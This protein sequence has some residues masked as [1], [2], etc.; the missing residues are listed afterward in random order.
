M[1]MHIMTMDGSNMATTGLVEGF[2]FR[3]KKNQFLSSS[4]LTVFSLIRITITSGE[5]K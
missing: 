4:R 2:N 3:Q 1:N 5:S